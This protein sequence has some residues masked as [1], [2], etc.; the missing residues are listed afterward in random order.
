MAG[1]S[2]CRYN[3]AVRLYLIRHAQTAWNAEQKAHGQ[4]DIP[5]DERGLEQ[6]RLL[7]DSLRHATIDRVLSSDLQRAVQTAEPLAKAFCAPLVLDPRLRER[8]FG[9]WEGDGFEEIHDR[10]EAITRDE[11]TPRHAIRPPGGESF[12]DVWNRM[13][14]IQAELLREGAGDT[15]VVAHGGVLSVL[16]ARLIGGN[17]ET[18]RVFRFPNASVTELASRHDGSLILIRYAYDVHLDSAPPVASGN[19]PSR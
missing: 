16:L 17:H 15:A 2:G 14:P 1:L 3:Q 5:L 13:E 18:H 8:A 11:G 19:A 12:V 4:E 6:A 10:L 9:E 7:A